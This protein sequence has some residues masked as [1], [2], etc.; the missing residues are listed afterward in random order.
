YYPLY[1]FVRRQ[2]HNPDEAQDL[3]QEFFHRFLAKDYLASVA[4]EKGRFGSFL[5]AS[6]KHFLGAARVREAAI[7]RGGRHTLVPLDDGT[8]EERY[9]LDAK[10]ELTPEIFYDRGWATTFMELALSG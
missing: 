5:R 3:T 10:S 7:K 1:T 2:G 8:V 4:P 9:L 6:L